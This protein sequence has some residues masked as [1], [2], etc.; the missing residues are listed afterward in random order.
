MES[1][2]RSGTSV[3][4]FETEHTSVAINS[5]SEEMVAGLVLFTLGGTDF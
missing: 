5:P 3:A 1:L 2:V 4:G